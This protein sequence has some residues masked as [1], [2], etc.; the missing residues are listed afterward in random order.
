MTVDPTVPSVINPPR[1]IPFALREKLKSELDRMS[2]MRIIKAESTNQL[3][4][5]TCLKP[6]KK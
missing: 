3:I 2:K 6:E 5:A 1:K 4:A